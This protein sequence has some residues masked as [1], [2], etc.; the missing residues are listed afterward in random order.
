MFRAFEGVVCNPERAGK[1][2]VIIQEWHIIFRRR[3]GKTWKS[4]VI[5]LEERHQVSC[6]KIQSWQSWSWALPWILHQAWNRRIHKPDWAWWSKTLIMIPRA[7]FVKWDFNWRNCHG[8]L[9]HKR[10][11][12]L[13]PG[14][15][16]QN[17]VFRKPIMWLIRRSQP[18]AMPRLSYFTNRFWKRWRL[19]D[20]IVTFFFKN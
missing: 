18:P 5:L 7:H 17:F 3:L 14:I 4:A 15:H 6:S 2:V 1:L 13:F 8:N 16:V 11:I 12:N 19:I 20:W 10:I 9:P